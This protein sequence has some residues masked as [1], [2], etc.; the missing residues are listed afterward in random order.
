MDRIV[1]D[2]KW[3]KKPSCFGKHLWRS[4]PDYPSFVIN[5]EEDNL[6]RMALATIKVFGKHTRP[7]VLGGEWCALELPLTQGHYLYRNESLDLLSIHIIQDRDKKLY[8][9][10]PLK[11]HVIEEISESTKGFYYKIPTEPI[12]EILHLYDNRIK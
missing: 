6:T 8:F 10:N 11:L 12:E 7:Y 1:T 4:Q 9:H 5:I 3:I 2:G